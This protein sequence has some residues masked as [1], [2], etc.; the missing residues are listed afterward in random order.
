[1][2]KI[3]L[4]LRNN[5]QSGPFT[6]EEL[7][8]QGLKKHDLNWVEGRSAGWRN[9][10]EIA[11]LT[12]D[13]APKNAVANDQSPAKSA[14]PVPA[15]HSRH[16]YIS[17]P[18]GST[19]V[20]PTEKTDTPQPATINEEEKQESFEERVL[21]MQQRVAAYNNPGAAPENK[22]AVETKYA[23]SLDDIK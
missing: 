20:S 11:E 2:Q 22:E 12:P 3:Y 13:A 9:P 7:L 17:L 18:S 6:R 4:L 1:M 5:K 15:H 19:H 14:A 10:E 16:I 23:R 8:Q 21:R